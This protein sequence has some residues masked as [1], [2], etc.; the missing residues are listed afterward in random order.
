MGFLP[1]IFISVISAGGFEVEQLRTAR[2]IHD[3]LDLPTHNIS[4]S[5]E[6]SKFW[7]QT[8][9]EAT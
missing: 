8:I 1:E 9:N 6:A 4:A 7:M 5:A 2:T 3:I